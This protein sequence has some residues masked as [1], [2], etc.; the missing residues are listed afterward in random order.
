M[1]HVREP[2]LRREAS[3][4]TDATAPLSPMRE[5]V[6]SS[7]SR[8]ADGGSR[9]VSRDSSSNRPMSRD[10]SS[11]RPTS[12]DSSSNRPVSRD[13]ARPHS[14]SVSKPTVSAHGNLFAGVNASSVAEQ[15]PSSRVHHL[16]K[17][18]AS[19]AH[20]FAPTHVPP[21]VNRSTEDSGSARDADRGEDWRD[22]REEWVP[23][24]LRKAQEDTPSRQSARPPSS[25]PAAAVAAPEPEPEPEPQQEPEVVE[26]PPSP[27]PA[28]AV[29]SHGN[30][31]MGVTQLLS[32]PTTSSSPR[33]WRA[34]SVSS[35]ASAQGKPPSA[36]RQSSFAGSRQG[37]FAEAQKEVQ[38]EVV[39][40]PEPAGPEPGSLAARMAA[41][42]T[43]FMLRFVLSFFSFQIKAPFPFYYL[44]HFLSHQHLLF[45]NP[46]PPTQPH[47]GG[48][49]QR[50]GPKSGFNVSRGPGKAPAVKAQGS[51]FSAAPRV[52]KA[53]TQE[54]VAQTGIHRPG[55]VSSR[56]SQFGGASAGRAAFGSRAK[57]I[58]PEPEPEPEPEP[59]PA[60][61][62]APAAEPPKPKVKRQ[63][64]YCVHCDKKVYFVEKLEIDGLLFHKACFKCATCN[65]K[66]TPRTYAKANGNVYCK[67][68]YDQHFKL[69]GNYTGGFD[70]AL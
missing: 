27:S 49:V 47:Q 66:L 12:R 17:V 25:P 38:P 20:H 67:S 55:S 63:G 42:G 35:N 23:P 57:A 3:R 8:E 59:T 53:A 15:K 18:Q 16:P 39:E 41:F 52:G 11:N 40:E 19:Q 7:P 36:S 31:F 60:P 2:A 54:P 14:S 13:G 21:P 24:S 4:D 46:L 69:K 44:L 56:M 45:Y 29:S 30:M 61:A 5:G 68:H 65:T 22:R 62:P 10:S 58:T 33:K 43:V 70:T 1:A 26:G 34:S 6:P 32:Q 9:P 37:S 48:A 28:K 50:S 51:T 64:D